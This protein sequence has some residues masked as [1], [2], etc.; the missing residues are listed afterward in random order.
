MK[1]FL[2]SRMREIRTSGSTRGERA[3]PFVS[4]AL[5]LYREPVFSFDAVYIPSK[6]SDF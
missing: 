2:V 1:R 5:L 4:F 3:A 6:T